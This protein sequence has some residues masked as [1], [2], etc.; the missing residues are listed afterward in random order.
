MCVTWLAALL[1]MCIG[2]ASPIAS[3]GD[4]LDLSVEKAT[5]RLE[6]ASSRMVDHALSQ[7]R[8]EIKG[9]I[10]DLKEDVKRDVRTLVTGAESRLTNTITSRLNDADRTQFNNDVKELGWWGA[11]K[12]WWVELVFGSGAFAAWLRAHV[13]KRKAREA[14]EKAE[15]SD[16]AMKVFVKSIERCNGGA[17]E[18][19]AQIAK[20]LKDEH[21]D[22]EYEV[23]KVVSRQKSEL[24]VKKS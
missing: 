24:G 7:A 3:A 21:P 4:R 17:E 23:R 1:W 10:N 14:E 8:N 15:L 12:N 2:C 5:V 19:K 18:I 11:L 6:G 20:T 13:F 22:I 9:T 16:G